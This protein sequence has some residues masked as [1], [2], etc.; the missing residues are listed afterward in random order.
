MKDKIEGRNFNDI[1]KILQ[2]KEDRPIKKTRKENW[3][4]ETNKTDY[5]MWPR[6]S[7][8]KKHE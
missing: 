6:W 3:L 7:H 8:N 1:G 5:I 4:F 2:L